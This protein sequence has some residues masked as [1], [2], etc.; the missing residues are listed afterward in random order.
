MRINVF[1]LYAGAHPKV[2]KQD[3]RGVNWFTRINKFI[4]IWLGLRAPIESK[5]RGFGG[6]TRLNRVIRINWF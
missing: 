3:F 6:S 4:V 2:E 1:M 5:N